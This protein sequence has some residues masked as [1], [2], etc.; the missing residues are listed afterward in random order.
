LAWF[1]GHSSAPELV[2]VGEQAGEARSTGT[3]NALILSLA[4]V[5]DLIE[6]SA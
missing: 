6:A 4:F 3:S 2:R 5:Y 1:V